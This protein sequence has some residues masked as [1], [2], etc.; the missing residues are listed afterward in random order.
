MGRKTSKTMA[1]ETKVISLDPIDRKKDLGIIGRLMITRWSGGKTPVKQEPYGHYMWSGKQR[2]GKS[3]SKLWYLEKKVRYYKRHKIT[4]LED[5]KDKNGK[6]I[7]QIARKF[8]TV[9]RIKVYSNMGIGRAVERKDLY[10]TISNLDPYENEVR[11]VL[12]DEI[13]AYFGKESKDKEGNRI[14]DK[15]LGLFSQLGKRNTYI[16]S[17]AQVYGRLDK[18]LREQCLYMINCRRSKISGKFLNEFIPG[19]DIICD[20]LGRWAGKPTKIY[21][22]GLPKTTYDTKKIITT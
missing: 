20:E 19:D 21:V 3:V 22:H 15:L 6:V 1:K 12:I 4:Y 16:F 17:T 10:E 18:A 14:K 13:Q 11:F 8:N 9:P 7:A 2:S 5:V